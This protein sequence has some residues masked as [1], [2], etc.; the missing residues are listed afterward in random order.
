MGGIFERFGDYFET[1]H[2]TL[3]LAIELGALFCL[4][5]IPF[6]FSLSRR[7][8]FLAILVLGLALRIGWI[9][10]SSHQPE[11][12]WGAKHLLESDVTNIHAVE[13]TRGIWFHN[14]EGLP[15]GR[16][17]IGYPLVLGGLY[18]L[19]GAHAAVGWAANVA[20]FGVSL[21][22]L[23]RIAESVFGTRAGMI[24]AFLLAVYPISVYSVKLMTDEHLFI[25]L[26][27]G[28]LLLL[29]KEIRGERI[30]GALWIY[31]VVFGLAT[32]TRTN[33]IFM[34][35][36]VGF[37]YRLIGRSWKSAIGAFVLVFALMMAVNAPWAVRNYR[38]WGVPVLYTATSPF[39]YAQ[40]NASADAAGNGHVPERGEPGFSE[41]VER[42]RDSGNEGAYHVACAR[43]MRQWILAN[44][45]RFGLMGIERVLIFMAW[46]RGGVWPIWFQY[47]PDSF[48][49]ARPLSQH[50]RDFLEESS[51]FAYYA[52]FFCAVFG[53][54]RAG[55]AR[56]RKRLDSG[57][58]AS[59]WMLAACAGFWLLQHMI[60][61]PDR[62]YRFPLELLMMI[63]AAYFLEK[64]IHVGSPRPRSAV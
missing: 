29:V 31:G 54:I 60:I 16:R 59:L 64:I 53:L 33:T 52:L 38:V 39:I 20:F 8:G 34:P 27:F 13:L 42:A 3:W 50:V 43:A 44:P 46:D 11:T 37:A 5:F 47:S 32:I 35:A 17:P 6:K 1:N 7:N 21:W 51:Y 15:S 10:F 14:A 58:R 41:E 12:E 63:L 40:V 18:K 36:V 24:A 4:R 23:F 61:Y 22:F 57:A 49:P 25:P 30:P 56:F 55:I 26:W 28:G 9:C 19:F 62:K 2:F 48:N 45:L